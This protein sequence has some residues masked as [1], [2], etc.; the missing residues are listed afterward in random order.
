MNYIHN[1]YLNFNT[2]YYD[3]YE[4]KDSDNIYHINKIPIIKVST[5]ILK[6]IVSNKIKLNSSIY[7]QIENKTESKCKEYKT[8]LLITDLKN[9]IAFSFDKDRISKYISSL[10]IDDEYDILKEIKNIKEK[11]F[12]YEIISIREYITDTRSDLDMKKYVLKT[13]KSISYDTLKYIYYDCFNKE[14]KNY[15]KMFNYIINK[16]NKDNLI[17]KKIYTTLN[18]IS[19]N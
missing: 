7:K 5:N 15:N 8:S 3:F 19:T 16:I 14:E 11:S 2:E 9:I 10:C 18:P 1:I 13:M 6:E 17:V 4:W 12:E